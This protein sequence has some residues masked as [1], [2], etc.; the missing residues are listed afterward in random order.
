MIPNPG[1]R[2]H[3]DLIRDFTETYKTNIDADQAIREIRCLKTMYP[4]VLIPIREGDLFA[5]KY[6]HPAVCFA[7]QAG[8]DQGGFAYS[9]R[10]DL[11]EELMAHPEAHPEDVKLLKEIKSFWSDE[12]SI[13]KT[14][15][16]YPDK[17][18]KGLPSDNWTKEPGIGFPL[19]R[20]AGTQL[21]YY[22]LVNI[23]TDGLRKR[24]ENKLNKAD[25]AKQIVFYSTC[26]QTLDLFSE[27]CIW[28]AD[29]AAEM[30]P[31]CG[32]SALEDFRQMELVLRNISHQKPENL[33]EAIQLSYLWC[34]LSGSQNYGRI[35]DYMGDFLVN[36]LKTGFLDEDKALRLFK[37]YWKIMNS[38]NIPY[39]GRVIIGGKGRRN[40]KTA[41]K[42]AFLA[43]ETASHI[44]DILPQ[45]TFRFYDGQNPE[46]Y[47][48]ALD[49]IGEGGTFPML[50][51]DEVN[52]PAAMHAFQIDQEEACQ[53]I[54]FG[55]GEYIINHR[56]VGTPSGILNLLK[57][58]E[59][60]L[61]KGID[62]LTGEKTGIDNIPDEFD[63][64]DE[65]LGV[66]ERQVKY[67]IEL[68]ALQEEIEYQVAGG[69]APF[70]FFSILYD[71][72]IERGKG[73]FSGGVRYLGGT[74]EIYG[75]TSAADSLS[76][77]R[78]LVFEE[79]KMDL[80]KLV[81]I[82]D[83]DFNGYSRERLEMLNAP[84]YGNDLE[85]ADQMATYLHDFV[86]NHTRDQ[87][88]NTNLHSY[89]VVNINNDA[90]TTLGKFTAASADGRK[91]FTS[92]SN[93][94][95]PGMGRDSSGPTALLNSLAKPDPTIHAGAVQN[96]K[97]SKE[98]FNKYREHLDALLN[99]Y[100][101]QGGTQAMITVVGKDDLENAMK[102]PEK[103]SHLIVRVGG[104]SARFVEL[105]KE[106]QME[107]LNRTLY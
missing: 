27:I 65:L 107:I 58:L 42:L 1:F 54:P 99:S 50:Y 62:P 70:L 23:G 89:L 17:L 82:L 86:C 29:R 95:S 87:R 15:Q 7:P 78:K 61:H 38:R 5:G 93:G 84:K 69:I 6:R 72:C 77:I 20:M 91:A 53:V 57:A 16:A 12:N 88:N 51:N 52:V 101:I 105:S 25:S 43:L 97:F 2:E 98:L 41:D 39:D 64:F 94:N 73:M 33:R 32:Q 80:K 83:A 75:Y 74:L 79:Q 21:D 3:V 59:V 28:Y 11:M 14:R 106:V 71:D 30:Q 55:C 40:E 49:T 18:Q 31:A 85:E 81:E 10:D 4:G 35:D 47:A 104:F 22:T 60:V 9:C 36:D 96:M 102:E 56:S 8:G 45:L 37:G 103:Y 67:Y 26:M 63:S 24:I 46:L 13:T 76:A 100:F 92:M 66:Y 44:K 48:K 19:Y 34:I 90:N 68:L